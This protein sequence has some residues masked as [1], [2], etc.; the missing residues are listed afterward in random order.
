M[1]IVSALEAIS[2]R[3]DTSY[4]TVKLYI[5]KDYLDFEFKTSYNV[6][7]YVVHIETNEMH[8]NTQWITDKFKEIIH[9]MNDQYISD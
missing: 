9:Y 6:W 1:G 5:G 4:Y 3:C 7:W 2:F 8:L